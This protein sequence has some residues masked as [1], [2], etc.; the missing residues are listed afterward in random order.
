VIEQVI[1][2][3]L[4]TSAPVAAIVGTRIHFAQRPQRYPLPAIVIQRGSAQRPHHFKGA[5]GTV[6]GFVR[7]T[8]LASTYLAARELAD[9]VRNR[10][11]GFAGDVAVQNAVGANTT[12]AVQYL[13][14]DDAADI[15]S[16]HRDGQGDI[17][18]HGVQIDFRYQLAEPVP[19]LA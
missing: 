14:H 15:P 6:R 11:D 19:S 2:A 17:L 5:A 18:T 8:C 1:Q 12:V 9:A 4:S 10:L 16:D 13:M 7:V 3:R